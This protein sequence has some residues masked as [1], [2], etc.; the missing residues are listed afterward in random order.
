[1]TS[2]MSID[3]E[4]RENSGKGIARSLR[5]AQR[6]PAII[7]SKGSDSTLISLPQKEVQNLRNKFNFMTTVVELNL[8][9]KK[10]KVLAKEMSLHPVSDLVEHIEFISVDGGNKKVKV[11]VPIRIVGAEKSAGLK[12]NA[13]LNMSK[14]F[15]ECYVKTD[16]VPEAIDI[17]VSKISV[18]DVIKLKDIKIPSSLEFK[19][20]NTAQVILKMS[21]K[22]AVKIEEETTEA[23]SESSE[24]NNKSSQEED[25]SKDN[26]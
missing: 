3:A 14:R 8:D 11:N 17:D 6:V 15:I 21:G 7:Y 18:G 20:K 13:V 5:R 10:R 9:G 16:D 12:R 1:M 4:I 22:R 23:E 2:T 26:K 25:N 24:D 19:T